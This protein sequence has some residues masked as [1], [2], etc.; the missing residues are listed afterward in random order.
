MLVLGAAFTHDLKGMLPRRSQLW[1]DEGLK[2]EAV[3]T[4]HAPCTSRLDFDFI[5][6]P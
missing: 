3:R 5:R 2:H 6:C 4:L 1:T